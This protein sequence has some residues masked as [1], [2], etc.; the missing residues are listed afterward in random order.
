M[1]LSNIAMGNFESDQNLAWPQVFPPVFVQQRTNSYFIWS[2]ADLMRIETRKRAPGT[3]AAQKGIG[4]TTGSYTCNQYAL[5]MAVPRELEW[6]ADPAVQPDR[7]Y[8]LAVAEDVARGIE[9]DFLTN[10]FT[11]GKW[12]TDYTAGTNYTAWD[13]GGSD[14][15]RD[16][17][18]AKNLIR[19]QT[20]RTPNRLVVNADVDVALK[21]HPDVK[22]R[23]K[24]TSNGA[25]VITDQMLA[26]AFGVE[27]YIVVSGSQ[28]TAGEAATAVYADIAGKHALLV[29]ASNT[30]SITTPSGGY[31]FM[32]TS[33]SPG[34]TQFPGLR[35][36]DYYEDKTH[37]RF[38]ECQADVDPKL[39]ASSCGLLFGS[40]VS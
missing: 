8:T 24:A 26:Q 22:D 16:V 9:V 4:L 34:G 36:Y 2:Q 30:P 31:T 21:N 7:V 3:Q 40:A 32:Q 37:T 17:H 14:P 20:K 35:M 11:T 25:L 12:G 33:E 6:N 27:R 15:I 38:L 29:Y 10:F 23:V 39:T 13:Q 5:A 19:R 1:A 18:L 28:N